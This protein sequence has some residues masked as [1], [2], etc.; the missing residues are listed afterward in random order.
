M[1]VLALQHQA[2]IL[3]RRDESSG[4]SGL[5]VGLLII[6]DPGERREFAEREIGL[7][8]RIVS[9]ASV[10]IENARLHE[11]VAVRERFSAALNEID[12]VI[13]STLKVDEIMQRV[14]AY[15]VGLVGADSAFCH[16]QR[17]I[18]T[19][20]FLCGRPLWGRPHFSERRPRAP[21][22]S[23]SRRTATATRTRPRF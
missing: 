14:V 13:H 15:S 20:I 1:H 8:E 10:A 4:G 16:P 2:I 11:E 22:A 3:R 21:T 9:Q 23:S 17:L 12:V 5:F 18:Q 6:D 7:V 19:A